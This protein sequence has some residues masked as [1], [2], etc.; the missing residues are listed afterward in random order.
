MNKTLNSQKQGNINNVRLS[1]S[2]TTED[3]D[4]YEKAIN[5]LDTEFPGVTYDESLNNFI[6]K[7]ERLKEILKKILCVTITMPFIFLIHYD[8]TK[9][10]LSYIYVFPSTASY[11]PEHAIIGIIISV[12]FAISL[13]FILP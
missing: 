3:S 13:F 9:L 1:Y 8:L 5:E 11:K 12:I 10:S 2:D 7:K 4:F 6:Y